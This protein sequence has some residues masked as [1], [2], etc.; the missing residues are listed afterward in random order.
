MFGSHL[1]TLGSINRE[2]LLV[3]PESSAPGN[4]PA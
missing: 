4:F 2:P 1:G 3:S